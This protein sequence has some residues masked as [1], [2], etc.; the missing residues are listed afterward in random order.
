MANKDTN[1][2]KRNIK[3]KL[4]FVLIIFIS[5]ISILLLYS[6]FVATS[7]LIVKENK[8]TNLS[9]PDELHGL[10]IIHLSDIHFGRIINTERL[11]QVVDKINLI[12][13][14]IVVI[15]G[16]LLDKDRILSDKQINELSNNLNNIQTTIGKYFITGNHD[17]NHNYL[18]EIIEK[19]NFINMDNTSEF[20]Y[21]KGLNPI[22]I[23]GMSTNVEGEESIN[24]KI[25]S[26]NQYINDYEDTDLEELISYK[27]MLM[28][29]PDFIEEFDYQN[30]DLILAGHSHN[31]QIRLPF[32]GAVLLPE[33]AKKYY[34]HHYQLNNTDLFISSGLGTSTF[35][36]RLFNKPSFNLYRLTNK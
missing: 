2:K 31:G 32:I 12:E 29:E 10:K 28:H 25:T 36:F 9:L 19:G 26:I 1:K 33:G 5:L 14:D 8:I 4:L 34:D 22:L 24:T 17:V 7:G 35:D 15:T 16:D 3:R 11:Q 27:I 20:I 21:Y 6:R 18:D 30:Y 23:S 13:P